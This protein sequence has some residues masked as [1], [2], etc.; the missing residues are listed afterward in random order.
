MPR[1]LKFQTNQR[2]TEA[3]FHSFLQTCEDATR[4]YGFVLTFYER[5]K[6]E[7]I[8]LAMETL[9]KMFETGNAPSLLCNTSNCN[10]ESNLL[11]DKETDELFVSKCI[12][13]IMR[14]PFVNVAR[15]YLEDILHIALH[16]NE[17][18]IYIESYI[19]NVLFNIPSLPEGKTMK[20]LSLSGEPIVILNSSKNELPYFD[21]SIKEA[22]MVLGYDILVDLFTC[23]LLEHQILLLA[24]GKFHFNLKVFFIS[25][26]IAQI[27]DLSFEVSHRYFLRIGKDM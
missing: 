10:Q 7:K 8:S 2:K 5:I 17:F 25:P 19:Y 14:K 6:N 15:K 18:N 26:Y 9:F 1:G 13:L 12:C 21:Y 4:I 11:Y 24:S 27:F 20:Y 3:K 16:E 22:L 23:M